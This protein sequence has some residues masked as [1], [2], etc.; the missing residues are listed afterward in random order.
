MKLRFTS[1]RNR[2][3]VKRKN[4]MNTY[5]TII[6][7]G[8][9]NGLVAAATMAKAGRRVLV[10]ERREQLGGSAGTE[11]LFP[12]FHFDTGSPDAGLFMPEIVKD[13]ALESLGLTF[14]ESPALLHALGADGQGVTFW[15]DPARTA[16][17]IAALSRADAAAYPRF[18]KLVASLTGVL[19]GMLRKAPPALP[20]LQFGDVLSWAGVA[21]RARQLG[22]RDMMELLRVLAMPVSELLDE[23]FENPLVKAGLATLAVRGSM[24]GPFQGGTALMLLYQA[25]GRPDGAIASRLAVRGGTGE[26]SAALAKAAKRYGAEIR[27]GAGV[28]QFMIDDGQV[29]GVRL[30]GGEEIRAGR[31]LSSA[32]PMTTFLKLTGPQHLAPEF[33]RDIRN[34]KNRGSTARV[35]LALST[36]PE[37]A[38]MEDPAALGGR[39]TTAQTMVE[40]E[41]AYDEAK[42]GS[43]SAQPA[44]EFLV[45]TALDDSLAPAGAHILSADFR[46]AP[47]QLKGMDWERG[48]E[49]VL[50]RTLKVLEQFSPGIA[51]SVLNARVITPQDYQNDY[52]LPEGSIYHGQMGLDQMLIMRPLGGYARYGTPI[53]GLYLCGSGAHPGGGVTGA[54]G[55]LAARQALKEAGDG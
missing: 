39:V 1:L 16:A 25:L 2:E 40:I 50:Q 3:G 8:G 47:C 46:F 19:K 52:G 17:G 18:A 49:V 5:E 42:Y 51:G 24:L 11:M 23:H 21:L 9:H 34:Y 35:L 38:G 53:R 13:L 33:I 14:I 30:T 32:D 27:T 22:S 20:D 41:R 10:L 26:L 28:M 54:P 48:R 44:L 37:F 4:L 36:R 6:I 43:I 31:V 12:G 7:G 15:R 29:A 45:P 55:Y